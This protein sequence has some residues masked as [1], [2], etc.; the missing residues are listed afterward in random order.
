MVR[1]RP[2]E[3]AETARTAHR[4]PEAQRAPGRAVVALEGARNTDE[5]APGRTLPAGGGR[6]LAGFVAHLIL[7]GDPT[8]APSRAT[9]MGFATARYEE[10]ARLRA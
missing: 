6:P 9:R 2:I 4:T 7:S 10:A 5:R 3:R 1:I 8:L